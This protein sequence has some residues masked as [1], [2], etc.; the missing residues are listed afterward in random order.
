MLTQ[1]YSPQQR[2]GLNQVWDG[3]E[4]YGSEPLFLAMEA[5]GRPD[6]YMNCIVGCVEK[7]YG[8]EKIEKLFAAWAGDKKQATL[9]D[10]AWLALEHAAYAK[11]VPLRPALKPLR[12]AHARAFFAGEQDLSRQEWMAKNQLVYS[13][14][15][16]RWRG[17]LG[18]K[19]RSLTPY[20]RRLLNDLTPD[21]VAD[22][23]D[24][25]AD[26][27]AAFD[28]AKLFNG[29][30]RAL[31]PLR[32][33]LT[34][35][36]AQW[37]AKKAPTE[38]V[39]TDVLTVGRSLASGHV[40]GEKLDLR[41]AVF[42][43]NENA[44]TDREYIESC[45]GL[46]LYPPKELASVEQLLCTENHQGCHLWFTAGVPN[47]EKA[48][49]GDSQ[50]LTAQAE[51]QYEENKA[52]FQKYHELYQGS[53][54]RLTEQIRECIQVHSQTETVPSRH[55]RLDIQK[56]WR[57]AVVGDGHVFL[58]EEDSARPAFSVDLLLD[59]SASRLH[60]QETVAA[61]GCILAE[62]LERCGVSV[63]VSSFC[64][65]RGYTVLRVLKGFKDK[66]ASGHIF[67]Y[68]AAGWNRDGL[69]LRAMG[70]L[71]SSAPGSQKLLLVLTDASPNDIHRIPSSP[72][73]PFGAEY[74][75]DPAV[76]DA[77]AEVRALQ[78]QGVRVGA[79]YMGTDANAPNAA[80][81]YGKSMVRI[82]SMDQL[83]R[84]AGRLI[85]DEVREMGS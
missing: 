11:E 12:E 21:E 40:G 71:L 8:R 13:L 6:L 81:I 69:A 60:C 75:G 2:R 84:A 41:R 73:H 54:H 42:K 56:V 85:Q 74:A 14:Q 22:G 5:T 70:Q 48:K 68:F 23:D 55:G 37:A 49:S 35:R 7:W 52:A 1:Q 78:R 77:A 10:L 9:D 61:Q 24:L 63:R 32:L 62:S 18:K 76:R 46:P 64:S 47:P 17:V 31:D 72:G 16:A 34:G 29:H 36:L 53:I 51:K 59:A 39:H 26:I 19:T 4:N 27:L 57:A 30:V 79:I 80:L 3:S 15:A 33:H 65:L 43:L 28:R 83:A 67:R 82:R 44:E 20:E 38:I 45:F 50:L 66:N 25:R 58:R